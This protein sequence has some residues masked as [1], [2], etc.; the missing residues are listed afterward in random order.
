LNF[1]KEVEQ[2]EISTACLLLTRNYLVGNRNKL[3]QLVEATRFNKGKVFDK[4]VLYILNNCLKNL[5]LK[6]AHKVL[7]VENIT[8]FN[9]NELSFLNIGDNIEQSEPILDEKEVQL[10]SLV[11]VIFRLKKL[12]KGNK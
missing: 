1:I 2:E 6:L 5:T 11:Y 4:L 12:G 3:D 8:D 7:S 10:L 9:S